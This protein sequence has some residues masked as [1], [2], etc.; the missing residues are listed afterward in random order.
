MHT[1][2][3][4]LLACYITG[5]IITACLHLVINVLDFALTN[6]PKNKTLAVHRY[7]LIGIRYMVW[8]FFLWP[9]FLYS[10]YKGKTVY[11]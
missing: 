4:L 11:H 5:A 2:V 10:F 3:I 1:I 6:L 8:S 9:H 7:W